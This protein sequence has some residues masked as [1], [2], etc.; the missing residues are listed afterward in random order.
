MKK[1]LLS[2]IFIVPLLVFSQSNKQI[3]QNYLNGSE[4]RSNKLNREL[5]DWAIQ[6]EGSLTTSGIENC[7]VIQRY[8]GIEIFRAVSNFSIKNKQVIDVKNSTITDAFKKVNATKSSLSVVDALGKAYFQLGITP[9]EKFTVLE[10]VEINKYKISNGLGI[11]EPV[12]ANLVYH[13]ESGN[14]LILAWDFNINTSVHDHLWSVRIDALNGKLL[15]KNDLVISCNFHKD[16]VFVTESNFVLNS[17]EM[18]PKQLYSPVISSSSGGSYRVI[19]FNVES[20]SHG[21]F[22]L[23][24]NPSNSNAS[25]FG[26]HDTDGAIGPEHTITRGN[27]V[28]AKDDFFASNQD[29][30]SSPDGGLSLLFDF[31]YG[32]TSVNASTYIEAANTNLFY[33]NNIMH[34]VWYQYGFDELSGNF[35][36]N[37]YDR[38]GTGGDYVNA[39][40][41]DGSLATPM[42]LN[43]ANFST[44]V[45]GNR[46][47]MQMFVWSRGPEI[48]PLIVTSPESL[49][50]NYV[51]TQN[52]F[53]PGRID[54]PVEPSF[55]QSDLVLYLDSFGNASEGC[56]APTN[57][58]AMNGKI[59][60]VRRGSCNFTV[61]VKAAQNQGAI[62]VIVV[63]NEERSIPM[64]GSDATIAIPAISVSSST[65][66]N[67]I[68]QMAIG[69]VNVK[70]QT[71]SQPFLNSDGDFDN[72]IIAHEYGHG[73]STRLAGGR[74]N[75]SCLTN[76]DQMGEGWSDWFALMMQLKPGD[77]GA[78]KRGIGTF[79]SSQANDGLGIRDYQYSTDREVNPMTYAFTNN[80][81]SVDANGVE[82]TSVHGVG[83]VWATMLWDLTW[84]YINK[85]GYDDN[86]YTGN[87]GNNRLMRIVLDG[88]KLQPCSPTFVDARNAIIAA[89]QAITG[90]KDYC[91]IWEVFAARG[92]GFN[93]SAGDRN[94]GNDQAEDFTR[95]AAGANCTLGTVDINQENVMRVYPNPSNGNITV[96]INNYN[97]L[98][99]VKVVD[100]NGRIVYSED[101]VA[102]SN[103]KSFDLSQLSAGIYMIDITGEGLKYVEKIIIN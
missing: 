55:L 4:A 93:A 73:I 94:I 48:K 71:Q 33:M 29:G 9:K 58:A 10:T 32:G 18:L 103:E 70:I 95:P 90:G 67:L 28:W 47:R 16:K 1:I 27:N 53:S 84:A 50:G 69:P 19:P 100:L 22:Q 51:A 91:L 52:S 13:Q 97:G 6:S 26:W 60:I 54:L 17:A 77:V 46:G 41:Q 76:K 85:Y 11:T 86:K 92:L 20:P 62:A 30:G 8:N 83:S 44:P 102:F 66:E 42:S 39:E 49:I 87:G 81:Q 36:E 12:L 101:K 5:S 80:F 57:A 37:N 56:S 15:E 98:V 35:Q 74:N 65:G 79:V 82:Q 88:I 23:I 45:D 63:N 24:S 14:K 75:S 40:A 68:A 99:A 31:P 72:G 64:S 59:V 34:D 3:I 38:G 61:K 21:A 78:A 25:P 43:N 89:D 2:V 96:R 7:Y